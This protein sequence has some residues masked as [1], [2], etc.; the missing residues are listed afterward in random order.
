MQPHSHSVTT[1]RLVQSPLSS[2]RDSK[3]AACPACISLHAVETSF[4]IQEIILLILNE[5]L[6]FQIFIRV[7]ISRPVLVSYF[8]SPDKLFAISFFPSPLFDLFTAAGYP[9]TPVLFWSLI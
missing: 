8:M 2:T 9:H 1:L 7:Y 6:M 3:Q 5:S 4:S